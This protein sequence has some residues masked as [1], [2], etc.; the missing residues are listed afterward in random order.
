[1]KNIEEDFMKKLTINSLLIKFSTIVASLALLVTSSNVNSTCVII[2]HQPE[3]PEG[4]K[5]LRRF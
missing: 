4:A 1:M 5:D 2:I 3:L